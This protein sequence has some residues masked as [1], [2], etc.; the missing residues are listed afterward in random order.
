MGATLCNAAQKVRL[1]TRQ[2]IVKLEKLSQ[3][4]SERAAHDHYKNKINDIWYVLAL[5]EAI[6]LTIYAIVFDTDKTARLTH[7]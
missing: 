5:D 7:T 2:G 4:D 3:M 6:C 1:E